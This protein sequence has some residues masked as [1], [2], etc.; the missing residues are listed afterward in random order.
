[1]NYSLKLKKHLANKMAKIDANCMGIDYN[2]AYEYHLASEAFELLAY[3]IEYFGVFDNP[4]DNLLDE[5]K[6]EFL[7]NQ[8]KH[9]ERNY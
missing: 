2:E 6:P 9:Y 7:N 1:M 4:D 5:L 8:I 3:W